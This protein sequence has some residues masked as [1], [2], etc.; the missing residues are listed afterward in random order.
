M[1]W[2][3]YSNKQTIVNV[4]SISADSIV[5]NVVRSNATTNTNQQIE[6]ETI[7]KDVIITGNSEISGPINI[8]NSGNS[9]TL[10]LNENCDLNSFSDI[11]VNKRND[12][13]TD[14]TTKFKI[15]A[16]TGDTE[17]QGKLIVNDYISF[18]TDF[19]TFGQNI[20]SG[21]M[22]VGVPEMYYDGTNNIKRK[23][24]NNFEVNGRAVI[25]SAYAGTHDDASVGQVA[26]Y[27]GLL[28]QGNVGIGTHIG[29]NTLDVYGKVMIGTGIIGDS[30]PA[31]GLAV[32]GQ[33][34]IG[35]FT[36]QNTL[37]VAG[38]V[39]IGD[40]WAGIHKPGVSDTYPNTD[41]KLLVKGYVG[42]GTYNPTTNL[43]VKGNALISKNNNGDKGNLTVEGNLTIDGNV[44]VK[45]EKTLL[46]T[47]RIVLEDSVIVVGN[48]SD[49]LTH[50]KGLRFQH[51][52]GNNYGFFGYQR[53]Y[54]HEGN[55]KKYFTFIPNASEED[56]DG[57][58]NLDG[59][60]FTGDRGTLDIKKITH[61]EGDLTITADDDLTDD[62]TNTGTQTY[63]KVIIQ[64]GGNLPNPNPNQEKNGIITIEGSKTGNVNIQGG[65]GVDTNGNVNEFGHVNIVGSS[66][67]ILDNDL[68]VK[69]NTITFGNGSTIVNTDANTLTITEDTLIVSNDLEITNDLTVSGNT[70]TFGNGSVIENTHVNTL[71]ITED[72]LIVSNDL[73]VSGNTIAFGNI[74]LTESTSDSN[75]TLTITGQTLILSNDLEINNDLTVKGNT[76]TFGVDDPATTIENSTDILTITKDI[77]KIDSTGGLVIP[78]G[79]NSQRPSTNTEAG[80]IRYNSEKF[81]FEG[82]SIN[83]GGSGTWKGLGGVIDIDQDTKIVA[84]GESDTSYDDHLRFYTG[85]GTDTTPNLRM[86][87]DNEGKIGVGISIPRSTFDINSTDALIIPV[88]NNTDNKPI[89][90]N[91]IE[92][93]IRYNTDLK[94][95]EGFNW[96]NDEKT[97][98]T[99]KGLGGVIDIDQDTKIVAEDLT[100]TYDDHLRFYTGN[101]TD[102]TPNLRM[103][104]DNEGKIGVGT[105]I[106]RSTFDI[107]STDALIIPVGNNTDNKP[108]GVNAI[109]GMIRYNTDLKQFEGFNWDNDEKTDG[110]WKGLGGVI[111]VDQDTKI[112]AENLDGTYDDHLRFYTGQTTTTDGDENTTS[113]LRMIIDNEG[114]IGVGTFIP[115]STFDINSTDALII[116]VGNDTTDKPS[117]VEGMIRYNTILKQFEG[118]SIDT[119]TELDT[120]DNTFSQR[121]DT[122]ITFDVLVNNNEHFLSTY[123]TTEDVNNIYVF[124]NG[125]SNGT[126]VTNWTTDQINM[127]DENKTIEMSL[128]K[129]IDLTGS[130]TLTFKRII[131]TWKGL[132]GVIDVDQDTKIVAEENPD[133]DKLRFY[134]ADVERM[135]IDDNG[136]VGIGVE[137]LADSTTKLDVNGDVK[138]T[139]FNAIS[140]KRLKSNIKP[141]NSSLDKVSQLQGVEFTLNNDE[142]ENKKIGF[143]AQDLER[144]LPEVVT[145]DTSE[146]QYKSVSYGNITALLVEAVKE[147]REEVKTLRQEIKDLKGV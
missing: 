33:V 70:I 84:E 134:T 80:T 39:I 10:T 65:K 117:G 7:L 88:G 133:E 13:S 17:I 93:M 106:P 54:I 111:D 28:V 31:N 123:L 34:G 14:T 135:V 99:W 36:P 75:S 107:N 94:Q 102:T 82:Y 79:N 113:E 68:T 90:V 53:E 85:N 138:A 67:L 46:E 3:Q 103:V 50:N 104:I 105:S 35:T 66:D 101:G 56:Q 55:I 144:V 114:K 95:F 63:G 120:G 21:N 43:E 8:F 116:P 126:Y 12:N 11:V 49:N 143:I 77:V 78:N 132:G 125:V 137:P 2:R 136:N 115:R 59:G 112:L 119:Y 9:S 110:T 48:D 44:T 130:P 140:D 109:E 141:L 1:S 98:G 97:D 146:D 127:G 47:Q 72:T 16:E 92:G 86:V 108:I 87:I 41:D 96:D 118:F 64:G 121:D 45:G 74:D 22:G 131:G 58:L 18:N 91:A 139:T 27:N 40:G 71:T 129:T 145:T 76:I 20:T 38:N 89:G 128:S 60:I 29:V 147:L 52:D 6:G 62:G 61:T 42:I 81:Q 51:G 57:T 25:G 73:T 32:Q 24:V 15:T 23:L 122:A 5:S 19:Y 83:S 26:D 142:L 100:G 4:S 124:I 30:A 69:G 37:D